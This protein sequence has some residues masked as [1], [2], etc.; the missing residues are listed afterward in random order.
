MALINSTKCW[1]MVKRDRQQHPNFLSEWLQAEQA[2][3][4]PRESNKGGVPKEPLIL[5]I[6]DFD[7]EPEQVHCFHA[8]PPEHGGG[9]SLSDT[10]SDGDHSSQ[11]GSSK[12]EV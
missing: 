8:S 12:T 6:N 5:A 3:K 9:D 1:E 7:D 11:S 4:K 2:K 10:S